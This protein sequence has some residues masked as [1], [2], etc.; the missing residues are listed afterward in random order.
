MLFYSC[1]PLTKKIGVSIRCDT[2]HSW[3]DFS[4]GTEVKTNQCMCQTLCTNKAF[5]HSQQKYDFVGCNRYSKPWET[6]KRKL[7]ATCSGPGEVKTAEFP[8]GKNIFKLHAP[9]A[10]AQL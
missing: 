10:T 6:D 7:K 4:S 5:R 1:F 2:S 8:P 9:W 3:R